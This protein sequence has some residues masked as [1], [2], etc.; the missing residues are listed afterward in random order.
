M[1]SSTGTTF[2]EQTRMKEL[3]QALKLGI[4]VDQV[5]QLSV[6]VKEGAN[7]EEVKAKIE[8]WKNKQNAKEEQEDYQQRVREV[9]AIF[10]NCKIAADNLSNTTTIEEEFVKS[11]GKFK[12]DGD[13]LHIDAT[14]EK[15][16]KL[17]EADIA[18]TIEESSDPFKDAESLKYYASVRCLRSIDK[19]ILN[20]ME[21]VN[22]MVSRGSIWIGIEMTPIMRLIIPMIRTYLKMKGYS[23]SIEGSKLTV[24]I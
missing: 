14:T 17:I 5:R 19:A 1:A 22:S 9:A 23:C 12:T 10:D 7:T 13:T 11:Y 21:D 4:T 16:A 24:C 2:S 20:G 8:R 3:D 18:N 6:F 15:V